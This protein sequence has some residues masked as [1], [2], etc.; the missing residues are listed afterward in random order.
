VLKNSNASSTGI[1]EVIVVSMMEVL[2]GS[3]AFIIAGIGLAMQPQAFPSSL[4]NSCSFEI[5]PSFSLIGSNEPSLPDTA[6]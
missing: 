6:A 1:A 4:Q 3:V 2:S 5:V